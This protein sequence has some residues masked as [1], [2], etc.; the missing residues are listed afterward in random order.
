MSLISKGSDTMNS[1]EV[2]LTMK[3]QE[4]LKETF[5]GEY[6]KKEEKLMIHDSKN[7]I[8]M[9]MDFKNKKLTRETEEFL[10]T[11]PFSKGKETTLTIELLD[12]K[13]VLELKVLTEIYEYKGRMLKVKYKMIESNEWIEYQIEF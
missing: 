2:T 4:E 5:K 10:L 12:S 9:T 1:V 11:I 6:N 13:Q 8:N 3:G 7:K